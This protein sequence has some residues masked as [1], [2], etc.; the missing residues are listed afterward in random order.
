MEEPASSRVPSAPGPRRGALPAVAALFLV[1][2]AFRPE[3]VAI[4]P[5]MPTIKDGLGVS[6][7]EIGRA[8]V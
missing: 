6:F 4:G 8:H 5:L 3:I 7:G 2:L 1:A